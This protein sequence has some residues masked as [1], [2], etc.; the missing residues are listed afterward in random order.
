MNLNQST[1][2]HYQKPKGLKKWHLQVCSDSLF[3]TGPGCV[4]AQD[5]S[6]A[7]QQ[8]FR[9]TMKQQPLIFLPKMYP[10]VLKS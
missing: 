5:D 1:S 6:S 3:G 2:I 10:H 8:I 9:P 7:Y 4:N